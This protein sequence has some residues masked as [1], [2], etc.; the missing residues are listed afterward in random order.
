M[1]AESDGPGR[2]ARFIVEL[3]LFDKPLRVHGASATRA[4]VVLIEDQPDA[5]DMARSLLEMRGHEVMVATTGSAGVNVIVEARPDLAL[6]DISLPDIDGYAVAREVRARLGS[7][8]PLIALTGLGQ[9]EDVRRSHEAGFV[10]HLTKPFEIEDLERVIQ[11]IL[12]ASSHPRGAG[13]V[14]L[15]APRGQT[16]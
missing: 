13:E 3:P 9:P 1:R 8:I 6:V 12:I 14:G 10:R 5:C 7:A 4:R 15:E 16:G 11:E 2:G